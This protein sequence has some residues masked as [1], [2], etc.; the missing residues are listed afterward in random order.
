MNQ[1]K[2]RILSQFFHKWRNIV[3]FLNEFIFGIIERINMQ[4]ST[5]CHVCHQKT[6]FDVILMHNTRLHVI[7]FSAFSNLKNTICKTYHSHIMRQND[8]K[9]CFLMTKVT[10][11]W[12]L[13][14]NT[15][16]NTEYKF[17]GK[18]HYVSSLMEKWWQPVFSMI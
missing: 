2:W 8:I 18:L 6:E 12:N 15:F 14:V 5:F 13:R 16:N 10:K 17:L 3:K 9:F 7:V 11:C 1:I 4:I